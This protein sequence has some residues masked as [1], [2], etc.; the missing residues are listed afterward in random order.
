[1]TKL[2]DTPNLSD[3]D[4]AYNL[5]VKAHEGLSDAESHAFNA[6]LI[7]ILM[8]HIGD[9]GALKEALDLAQRSAQK[10]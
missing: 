9:L 8:N 2:I 3:P 7:L 6:R 10:N 5:L 4:A 1:M